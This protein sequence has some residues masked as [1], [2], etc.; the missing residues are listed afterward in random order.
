[1]SFIDWSDAEGMIE[2]FQEFIRDE[3]SDSL[4]DTERREFLEDLLSEVGSMQKLT[5][6]EALQKLREIHES[7]QEE[8]RGDPASLH[9]SDLIHELER[10][11]MSHRGET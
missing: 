10:N 11:P 2:L 1:M 8:F 4:A 3:W 7:I 6:V 5:I 9:L